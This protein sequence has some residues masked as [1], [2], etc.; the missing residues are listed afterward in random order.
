MPPL[1]SALKEALSRAQ[2]MVD[3]GDIDDA[4][5]LL[6]TEAW[7]AAENNSHKVQVISLAAEAKVAK[8]DIDMTNRKMH[9]QDAHN[10]YQR[11]LKLEPSNKEIRRSQ[12]KLASMMDE[13]SISLGKGWQLFDDG[14]PTPAGLAAVFVGVMVFLVAFKFAGE[15]LEVENIEGTSGSV[16]MELSWTDT[17]GNSHNGKIW[18]QLYNETPMHSASFRANADAARYDGTIFH[19]IVDGF[20]IQGGDFENG[21]GTGGH[22]GQYFGYCANA[23]FEASTICENDMTNWVIPAEFGQTHDPGVIAAA[24]SS[25]QNSAGSQFYLVDSNGAPNLDGQYTAFGKAYMGEID[26]QEVDGITV[27]DA[28]S[29]VGCG[30]NQD[31]CTDSNKLST[32]PVTIESVSLID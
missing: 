16:L 23:G 5:E 24:R 4:L 1:P 2:S 32:Y 14:N 21:D 25:H 12:N 18:I 19:R 3:S 17:N 15:A 31:T 13:Q 11:A 9:W 6:R 20:M 29:Q 8:G 26:G 30:Q 10:S 7:A 27:I 28:I 22:A